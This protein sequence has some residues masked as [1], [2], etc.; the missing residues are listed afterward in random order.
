MNGSFSMVVKQT[1][2]ILATFGILSAVTECGTDT[3]PND[4]LDVCMLGMRPL[5]N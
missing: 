2:T 1:H 3:H 5:S 4:G